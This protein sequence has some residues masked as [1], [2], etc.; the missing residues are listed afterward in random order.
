MTGS[1]R[2]SYIIHSATPPQSPRTRSRL[3]RVPTAD[4]H[5]PPRGVD[6][7]DA[8]IGQLNGDQKKRLQHVAQPQ[9]L[10]G[11]SPQDTKGV[12]AR[13]V[14]ELHIPLIEKNVPP[15]AAKQ[16]R[17]SPEQADAIL[18]EVQLLS[19]R[20]II[21]KWTSAWATCCVTVQTNGGTSRLFQGYACLT[22]G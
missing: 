2:F 3:P 5:Q 13:T 20:G 9:K 19:G 18:R 15:I 1:D 8:N 4:R 11:L 21:R 12:R 17:F 16:Q 22:V 14:G 7:A 6:I 10:V